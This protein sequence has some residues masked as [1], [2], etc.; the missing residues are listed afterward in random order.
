MQET[1]KASSLDDTVMVRQ[2]KRAQKILKDKLFRFFAEADWNQDG[3]ISRAEFVE[4]CEDGD[5]RAWL[6]SLDLDVQQTATV[7]DLMDTDGDGTITVSELL[8]NFGRLRGPARSMDLLHTMRF[9]G[10]THRSLEVM[11]LEIAGLLQ[12]AATTKKKEVKCVDL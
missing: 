4:I 12:G 1:F 7:F 9:I 10:A 11:R 3:Q 6:S 2:K 8:E 5:I